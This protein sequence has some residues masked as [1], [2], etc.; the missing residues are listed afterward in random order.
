MRGVKLRGAKLRPPFILT[1]LTNAL[2]LALFA[3][4]G[5][6]SELEVKGDSQRLVGEKVVFALLEGADVFDKEVSFVD[7][8]GTIVKTPELGLMTPDE[9]TISFFI[10]AGT[11]AGPATA[12]IQKKGQEATYDVPLTISRV[13]FAL[14][15]KGQI[16]TL[17]LPPS[18]VEPTTASAGQT[19]QDLA[20]SPDGRLL[21]SLASD[22]IHFWT[23]GKSLNSVA[24]LTLSNTR[25]IAALPGGVAVGTSTS[26]QVYN[27]EEGKGTTTGPSLTLSGTVALGVSADGKRAVALTHCDTNAD[28]I[29]DSDCAVAIDLAATPPTIRQTIELDKHVSA[30]LLA[31]GQDGR[32]AVVADTAVLYGLN[33][34]TNPAKR[35]EFAWP[36][37]QPTAIARTV[38]TIAG[39]PTDL[40]AIADTT[41]K[42]IRAVGFNGTQRTGFARH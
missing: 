26:I 4:T 12:K 31:V 24:A 13:G 20:I 39:Q 33:F 2:V 6:S 25:C 27:Y 38:A 18:S 5:C 9:H 16:E 32:S 3:F 15:A 30:T 28:T 7:A 1:L 23:M 21:I 37:A 35:S 11:A 19:G 41:T 40:F 29:P 34:S 42:E 17:P 36:T 10:P 14:D 22:E 8:K